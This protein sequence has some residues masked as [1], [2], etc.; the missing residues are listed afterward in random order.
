MMLI[1]TH[2]HLTDPAYHRDLEDCLQRAAGAGVKAIINVGFTL[3]HARKAVALARAYP[4]LYATVGI[5]PHDAAGLPRD[6][7]QELKKL[8]A[9]PRVVALGELGLDFYR[10]LSPPPVQEKVFREQLRLAKEVGL[11]VVIHDRDA[12]RRILEILKE[13]GVGERGGVMHCFSG[14]PGLARECVELGLH[15]SIAGPVTYA[16]ADTLR[17]V[18]AAC[19]RAWLLL[20]TDCPYLTP[21]P[22]RGKRNE[23]AHVAL[24]CRQVAALRGESPEEVARFTTENA[25]KLFGLDPG[26]K[27]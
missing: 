3:P 11:P 5:H 26:L 4:A 7:L 15:I 20:E 17:Q 21:H 2:A 27:P 6:Y 13:E 12:H 8:A 14:D 24:V 10:N 23:P 19:P 1:D 22:F 25:V 18:A 16:K 9:S